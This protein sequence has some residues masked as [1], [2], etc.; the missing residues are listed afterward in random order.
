MRAGSLFFATGAVVGVAM[1]LTAQGSAASSK[2]VVASGAFGTASWTLSATDSPD[3]HVCLTM[4]LPHHGGSASECGTIFGS[5]AGQARG[6]TFLTHTGAPSPNYIV[7]PVLARA[8]TVTIRLASGTSMTT[9]T[10]APPSGLT[11]K[12]RFYAAQLPCPT[13]PTRVTGFDSAHRVVADLKIRQLR[14]HG[15]TTC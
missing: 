1:L 13:R 14:L 4:T 3:G 5:Q 10:I 6:I 15:K 12:I 9:K 8:R 2:I 11:S 7:G